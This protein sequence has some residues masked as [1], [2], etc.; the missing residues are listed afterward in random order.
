MTDDEGKRSAAARLL[1]SGEDQTQNHAHS[2]PNQGAPATANSG[3]QETAAN[4]D[5]GERDELFSG[6]LTG[7]AFLPGG[8][9]RR[10]LGWRLGRTLLAFLI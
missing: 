9:W 8:R 1:Y 4:D 10:I 7:T 2:N 5:D 3:S 6:G